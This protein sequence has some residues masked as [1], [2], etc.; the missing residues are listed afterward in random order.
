MKE[1]KVVFYPNQKAMQSGIRKM[2]SKGW[3]VVS[4]QSVS[5]GYSGCKT[6]CLGLLFFPL[7]LLGRKPN[8]F[9]VTYQRERKK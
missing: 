5:R 4:T 9:Q 1:T 6:C 3:E 8:W 2:Q 7:A